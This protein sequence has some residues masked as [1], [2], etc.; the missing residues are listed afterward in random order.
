MYKNFINRKK[1]VQLIHLPPIKILMRIGLYYLITTLTAVQLLA[2]HSGEA[3]SLAD[4]QVTLQMRN[5]GVRDWFQTIEKQTT[6]R[7]AFIEN[8]LHGQPRVNLEKGV[9][10]VKELL[11]KT[12]SPLD[13]SY[14]HTG[15]IVYIIKKKPSTKD[16]RESVSI[17]R[18]LSPNQSSPS[19]IL[20]RG[21]VNDDKGNRS[22]EHTSE[23]QSRENLVCR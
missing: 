4:I 8:Q 22:E 13:L 1:C 5:E 21:K 15:N 3:Q 17:S 2:F 14:V 7:F 11:H 18:E 23:L 6:L 19:S 10:R 9:Y 12:L 16:S 20:V